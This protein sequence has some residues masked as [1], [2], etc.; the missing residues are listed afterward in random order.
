MSN[1]QLK[2]GFVALVLSALMVFAATALPAVNA[3]TP[4]T[5]FDTRG[6]K[7]VDFQ[8]D[9]TFVETNFAQQMIGKK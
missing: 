3:L 9:S 8:E 1:Q 4:S 7:T 6:H 5:V 2:I